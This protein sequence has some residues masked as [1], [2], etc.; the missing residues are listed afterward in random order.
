MC[1]ILRMGDV[2]LFQITGC[3]VKAHECIS[4]RPNGHITDQVLKHAERV[5]G[6]AGVRQ[7]L[8]RVMRL[9]VIYETD[10]TPEIALC[11][12]EKITAGMRG[13]HK[14]CLPCPTFNLYAPMYMLGK[15]PHV[16][17]DEL[18]LFKDV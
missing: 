6:L 5:P 17:H 15:C 14:R 13:N 12:D 8:D 18:G 4:K 16:L 2:E 10:G 11:I 3:D 9:G 7:V 1:T